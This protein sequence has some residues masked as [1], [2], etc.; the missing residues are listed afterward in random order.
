[1]R[2]STVVPCASAITAD[3]LEA[4]YA[5]VRRA[6]GASTCNHFVQVIKSAFRWGTKKGYFARNPISEDAALK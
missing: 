3:D 6:Q 2:P 1:V 5:R 4:L